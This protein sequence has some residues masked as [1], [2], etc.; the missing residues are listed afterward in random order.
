MPRQ[1][2]V[3]GSHVVKDEGEAIARCSGGLACRAQRVQALIHF[4]GRRMMD[5][6]GLGD[7]Y[8]ESLVEFGYVQSPADLY[9]LTLA[10]LLEMKR[11]ADERDGVVPETV[12]Q[13]KIATKWAE[14]LIDAIAAS[15]QPVL[16]RL[17]FALG[18]RHIGES[19]AKVLADWLGSLERIRSAPLQVF[20]CLPDI[21]GVVA[22]SLNEFFSEPNNERVLDELLACGVK[23]ADERAP[24]ARLS[25]KLTTVEL[26]SRMQIPRLTAIRA[27]QLVDQGM[28]LLKLA[29][30]P[31]EQAQ[32][33]GLPADVGVG[34]GGMALSG[35]EPRLF[36][37]PG[38]VL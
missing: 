22:E 18:I 36:A 16:A 35:R 17:L 28:D 10:H 24:S 11:R 12:Q 7:R 19:T 33:R 20:A 2:P 4:A 38:C 25:Q 15:K 1:C 13:G 14:N 23:P 9:R 3:C 8:I 30:L 5:I 26:L 32:A 37:S 29:D 27:Q 34:R 6:D 31:A 21:G